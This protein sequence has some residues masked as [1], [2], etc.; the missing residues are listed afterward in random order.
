MA[1][2]WKN[3]KD[4]D[5]YI[6]IWKLVVIVYLAI[7]YQNFPGTQKNQGTDMDKWT[8][9]HTQQIHRSQKKELWLFEIQKN[10][11]C[12]NMAVLSSSPYA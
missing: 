2:K 5:K 9:R 1:I 4:N 8:D 11:T 6:R 10:I 7:P 3:D 12:V